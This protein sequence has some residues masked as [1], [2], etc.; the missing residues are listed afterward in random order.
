MQQ[1]KNCWTRR[2]QCAQCRIKESRRLVL[3]RTSF[4]IRV[5]Y[6]TVSLVEVV[7]ECHLLGGNDSVIYERIT[8]VIDLL[9]KDFFLMHLLNN[10]TDRATAACRRS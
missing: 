9:M 3:P 8:C 6:L 7:S 1:W 5:L 2:F 10:Y 4:F